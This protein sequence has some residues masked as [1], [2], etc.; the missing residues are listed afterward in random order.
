MDHTLALIERIH[1]GDKDAR[2]TL[3]QENMG[4]IYSVA[5]RF[6]GRGIDM[7]DLFQIGSIGLLKAV[8]NFDPGFDVKFSTY[9]VPMIMGE[10]KRFLRDDGM[11]KVSRSIK[12]NQY[13]IYKMREKMEKVLGREPNIREL[14]KAMNMSVEELAMTMESVT[15]VESIYRTVYQGDGSE[16]QLVDRLPE[17]KNVHEQT[18]DK[19][20]LEELLEKL[21]GEER[22]L[23][24]MRYFQDMTQMEVAGKMGISQVQV[25]RME[26]KVLKK[27]RGMP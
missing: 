26:K 27:L 16:I 7:E 9:A 15:E 20:F 12:E 1:Q 10:I 18:L 2:D 14:S 4:L 8:D 24:G 5:R 22:Q 11:L 17:N 21:D 19:I 25:S 13:K 3:F 6:L 23:I